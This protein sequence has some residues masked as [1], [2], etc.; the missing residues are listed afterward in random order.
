MIVGGFT[1]LSSDPRAL[2]PKNEKV[3]EAI[4]LVTPN[5]NTGTVYVGSNISQIIPLNA[6]TSITIWHDKLTDIF[7]QD[8][9]AGDKILWFTGKECYCGCNY[10]K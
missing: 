6:N 3:Y 10:S 8:T 4:T 9:T 2:D 7:V 1:F 5:S